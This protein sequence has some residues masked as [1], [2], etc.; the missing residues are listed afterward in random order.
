MLGDINAL[1]G[2]LMV[3]LFVSTAIDGYTLYNILARHSDDAIEYVRVGLKWFKIVLILLF[4][5]VMFFY[6]FTVPNTPFITIAELVLG[7][8]L[9]ADGILSIVVKKK[10]GGK[11]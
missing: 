7:L 11:K 4:S 9:L 10:Y 5:A 8:L 1:F 2:M 6:S 3:M